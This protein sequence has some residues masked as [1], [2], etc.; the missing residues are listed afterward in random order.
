MLW[1]RNQ[2]KRFDL[3]SFLVCSHDAATA[4]VRDPD[5][6]ACLANLE[7]HEGEITCMA[8][9]PDG[10]RVA[11]GSAD[12]TI[13]LWGACNGAQL[14]CMRGH[15]GPVTS[16]AF[17]PDGQRIASGSVDKTVR[18]WDAAAGTE[19]AC[20]RL[21]DPGVWSAG[22]SAGK[23]EYVT[24]GV[25]AVAFT[26]GGQQI[27]TL[28]RSGTLFLSETHT[29]RVWDER[30]GVCLK[31][32]QGMGSFPAVRA[33][34][35]WQAVIRGPD[36]EITSAETGQVVGRFPAALECLAAHPSG[37]IWAGSCGKHLYHFALE[38]RQPEQLS[39]S[40]HSLRGDIAP[41][42]KEE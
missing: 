5:S 7:G 35:R 9:S 21:D 25:S 19:R 42:A 37:R 27:V 34:S 39:P 26:A 18:T 2:S 31:T 6:G 41:T 12:A 14:T 17:S 36:V 22:W 40:T 11:S 24:Y 29:S 33:G 32:L 3:H 30:S 8:F 23:G 10:Q 16:V 15:E 28:S 38:G 13:R 1:Q 4:E 20:L